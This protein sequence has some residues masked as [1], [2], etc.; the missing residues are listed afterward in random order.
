MTPRSVS[1][2]EP[3]S[4]S[5]PRPASRLD[6]LNVF[7]V[8][9]G[10]TGTNLLLTAQAA[11]AALDAA[12]RA[13]HRV[14]LVDPRPRR[15]PRRPGQLRHDPRPAPPRPRRPAGRPAARR[16]AGLRRRHAEGGRHRVH[17]GR[18]P[19]GGH[20]PHRRP[21]RRRG[22]GR[23]RRR[24]A[25]PPSPTSSAP[26][27]TAP[28]SPSRPRPNQL[29]VL[30]EAGVVD[31]GGAGLCLVLDALVTTVTGVEPARAAA[32]PARPRG[33]THSGEH[34]PHQPPAGPGSEVQY[35]LADSDE[36]AVERLHHR[37][38][39]PRRQPRRRRRRHPDRSRV[40]RPRA[41]RRRRRRDRGRHRGRPPVPHLGLPAGPG[42]PVGSR[43]GL[44]R[45]RRRR[46]AARA[47]P[48]SSAARASA[49]SP[50]APT[51]SPRR[52]I[53]DE[54]IASA[55]L[56]VVVLPNDAGLSA[57]AA[58]AAARA[59]ELG[60]DVGVVPTRSPVQGLAAIA[61]ADPRAPLRRRRDRHGRGRR[62][63]PLGR[64][65]HRRAGGPHLGRP[66]PARRRPRLGRGRRRGDRQRPRR[67]RPATSSTGCS[68]PAAR[69]PPSSSARTRPSATPSAGTW[70]PQH[71]TIEVTRYS[72]GPDGI[73]LQVGVE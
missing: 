52:T 5:C 70:P 56:E 73:L 62:G 44:P 13:H 69:W 14:R 31:A 55:A 72:G 1:G 35:L 27:P 40:E 59:R 30:R 11:V 71:P 41:R 42:P 15:R 67:R 17:R 37:L 25:T 50:A 53:L 20:L 68:R 21:R 63:H 18:R 39:A 64:G 2:T 49:S 32:R 57:V 54:V 65:H 33:T 26:R 8:P 58:R 51:A 6:D 23:R 29:E 34:L 60:R 28:A 45:G 19:R 22:R 16:R 24:R 3:R 9:D 46:R 38:A 12:G 47:S 66:L 10:D 7:P 43:A 48:T 36:G 4:R 61:V